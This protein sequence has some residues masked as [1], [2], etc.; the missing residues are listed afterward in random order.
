[1]HNQLRYILLL[2]LMCISAG[3]AFAQNPNIPGYPNQQRRA[4]FNKD[5]ATTKTKNLTGDQEID[6]ER[7]KEEKKRDS[8]IFTSKFI[9][10]TNE[11]LLTDSTQVF[12]L[13]T[14]L[15]NFENYSPLYQPR[16]P[17]IGLGNLG[18][19]ERS[20]LFEPSKTIGFDVGQHFL[21]A[22]LFTP[23][24]VQYYKARVPYTNLS[25]YASG[26]K[27]QYFKVT[28]TQNINPQ[29]NV[30]FNLNFIGSRGSYPQQGASDLTGAIFSWY[31]SKSKRYNLLANYTFNN[32]K[33]PENGSILND[34]LF[35][36]PATSSYTTSQN[37]LVRLYNSS[38]NIRKNGFYIKQFYYI[39]KIDSTLK[40]TDK[41]KILP[42][43]RVSYTLYYSRDTYKFLQN[44]PDIYN[45]F[46][47]YYYSSTFS[48]DSLSVFHLQNGFS[49]S[50]YLR[51][52]STGFVKNEVKLDLG[53]VQD[54]YH[55]Q[56]Y[57]TDTITNVNF[58][59]SV[60]NERKQNQSFQ[61]ITL[62]AKAS[63]RFSD[64]ILLDVDLQQIAAG[65]D[66]GDFLYDAKLTLSGGNKA[67]KIILGAYSQSST[68][69]LVYTD[70]ISNHYIFHN[71]FSNQ[72]TT[73]LS[74]NYINTPLGLD[75][76]AEY[77]LISDYLYFTAQPNG[78]DAT[79]A[80]LHT[81]INLLKIS[82]GKN[83]A[84]RRWHF[85]NYIV[86]QKTDYQSTLRTPE[87]YTYSSLYYSRLLFN[88]LNSSFGMDVRYN[89]PYVAPSYA[90][91]LGQFYNSSPNLTFSSYPIASV[92]IK[93]TLIRTNI[94]I[95]YDYANQGLFSKGYYMVNRYPGPG[96]LLKLGVSWSFYN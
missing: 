38:D 51:G 23:Q 39:G 18:L 41:S 78:I 69:P 56:Q 72:K 6:A 95:Q 84:W 57:V 94:F 90:V 26:V 17:K 21:D 12:P 88:V 80:Q 61:D 1:M 7:Q 27:E 54:Y 71:S 91:G 11:R 93:A 34:S 65:R 14:G 67:G 76:K 33:A 2:L 58:G 87:V 3:F 89:T 49:Y 32:L 15:V 55:Y 75:L 31:E 50:F 30:G 5:T 79:P 36:S 40:G 22:Y 42:T 53:L 24:D 19:A 85:D 28:H 81:P 62:K 9:R 37:Q 60:V 63:Y 20:L 16:S 73:N 92:F 74:F 10:V 43:Q 47:D 64:R 86:Y 13:D 59:R 8:V 4:D 25:L 45:V 70:W 82:L 83:L 48:R 46:P 29:L 66:F 44:E 96:R 68:P 77:F 35:T 52:K